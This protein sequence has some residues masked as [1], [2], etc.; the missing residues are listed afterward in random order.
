MFSLVSALPEM[1]CKKEAAQQI[2]S[3][4]RELSNLNVLLNEKKHYR[5]NVTAQIG[6]ISCLELLRITSILRG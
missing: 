6:V 2:Y 4:F 3:S 1:N 5:S